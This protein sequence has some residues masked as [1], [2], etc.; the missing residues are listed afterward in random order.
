MGAG[1]PRRAPPGLRVGP[2]GRRPAS[3]G[4]RAPPGRRDG[5]P[6]GRGPRAPQRDRAPGTDEQL[7]AAGRDRARGPA[8]R[9]ADRAAART[10][11]R[12]PGPGNHGAVPAA[13]RHLLTAGAPARALPPVFPPVPPWHTRGPRSDPDPATEVSTDV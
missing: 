1:A 5:V 2:A 8:L 4:G 6:P 12:P 3:D 9:G 7:G 13:A 11:R 10:G